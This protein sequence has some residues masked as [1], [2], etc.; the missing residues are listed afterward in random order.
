MKFVQIAHY[1]GYLL[2][3]LDRYGRR[4]LKHGKTIKGIG[5]GDTLLKRQAFKTFCVSEWLLR[6]EQRHV[7]SWTRL[8]A[9]TRIS[10]AMKAGAAA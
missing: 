7:D 3:S 9:A 1:G 10:R 5:A 6:H 2:A 4:Q 8:R